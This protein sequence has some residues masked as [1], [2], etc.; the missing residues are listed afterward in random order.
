MYDLIMIYKPLDQSDIWLDEELGIRKNQVIISFDKPP[1]KK[2][3]ISRFLATARELGAVIRIIFRMIKRNRFSVSK[4]YRNLKTESTDK[5]GIVVFIPGLN[6][7]PSIWDKRIVPLQKDGSVEIY[8]PYIPK[9]G[10]CKLTDLGL[11][12]NN[13]YQW[14]KRN[15]GKPITF[16]GHSN[17][18]RYCLYM[19]KELRKMAPHT[20]IQLFLIAGAMYGTS[21][22]NYLTR[23]M[24]SKYWSIASAGFLTE[25]ACDQLNLGGDVNKVLLKEVRMP[26]KEHLV[27]REYIKYA[28]AHD[29]LVREIGSSLPVFNKQNESDYLIYGYGHISIL[30][31]EISSQIQKCLKFQAFYTVS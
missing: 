25:V 3:I 30:N 11:I 29:L 17:G 27:K 14:A 8:A 21:L 12:Y 6:E 22:I 20:P 18:T 24:S 10:H 26:L 1:L 13:V 28:S 31:A 9:Q 15:P 5:K 4:N 23:L 16:F 7:S 2:R 19:E